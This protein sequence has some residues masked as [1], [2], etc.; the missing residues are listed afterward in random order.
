M[1]ELTLK[2]MFVAALDR[3][4]SRPA[5]HDRGISR[6]Y[7]Q[8]VVEANQL[9]HRLRDAGV[10][11]G[12]GVALMM[13]N[14]AE[15]VVADQAVIRCGAVK[16]PLNDMLSFN[17]I[18]HILRDSGARVVIADA[19]MLTQVL[20]TTAPQVELIIA[21]EAPA[22][23]PDR[24][25]GWNDAL[26]GQSVTAPD[27]DPAP[28]DLGMI[29]YTG[30]TTGR[31]K[32]VMH[33]QQGLTL[34]LLAHVIEM[35]LLDDERVLLTTPLPHSAGFLLQAG[36]L[37]GACHYLESKFDAESVL[38]RMAVDRV[39]F[40]FMVPTMIYR[41]LDH[42]ADRDFDVSSIRTILYGAAPI[43][44]ER[45]HQ[46]LERFGPVFMQLYG[47]SEA[48]NFLTRL[49]R[50]DHRA[51]TD[52]LASCGQA[53][54]MSTVKV[55][56]S[57]GR[58]LLPGEVGEIIALTPYT[59]SG[60]RDLSEQTEK[61]LRDGW[62]Y[63]GDIGRID[64]DGFVYLLDRKNDMVI[65]GGMNVYCTEVERIVATCRGVADVAV[66]GIPHPDW[67]EAVVAFVVPEDGAVVDESE[68]LAVC[69]A[70]LARYKQPKAIRVVDTV[71]TT[72]YGKH[73][74]KALR[75]S[76]PGWGLNSDSAP[77][78]SAEIQSHCAGPSRGWR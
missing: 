4:G 20:R 58:E 46:G 23:A 7:A 3:F 53:A 43:T 50:E 34:N 76:W 28:T 8:I 63:T 27:I 68:L 12:V 39:T 61:A 29:M 38:E 41:V 22:D 66:V 14:R 24:V 13:S 37:K 57:A 60:Y 36:M 70:E 56:D 67:G 18:D 74:K 64:D 32:G 47:Q 19:E 1:R 71:P 73:D 16:V 33:T 55:V 15:Y 5:V 44:P 30:G 59:F 9:A 31:P 72:S 6:S 17:D 65:T 26:A 2:A 11:P 54:T 42:A 48:P 52:R 25:V 69:R 78:A 75:A 40:T 62:L 45:L 77:S 49:R 10:G 51:D 21:T 35:G